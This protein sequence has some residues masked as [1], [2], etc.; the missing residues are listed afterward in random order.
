MINHILQAVYMK[1]M[2]EMNR[3][4]F[5]TGHSKRQPVVAENLPRRLT[6]QLNRKFS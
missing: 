3:L 1:K 4:N 5:K 2:L 6:R